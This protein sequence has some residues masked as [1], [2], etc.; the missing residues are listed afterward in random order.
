MSRKFIS[1]AS[2]FQSNSGSLYIKY[3]R[4]PVK[5]I[6]NKELVNLNSELSK[7]P[8]WLWRS[9]F[10]IATKPDNNQQSDGKSNRK[11]KIFT[12]AYG[13]QKNVISFKTYLINLGKN[14]LAVY[15][16][17]HDIFK[18]FALCIWANWIINWFCLAQRLIDN[19]FNFFSECE[20]LW[21]FV[22]RY[23]LKHKLYYF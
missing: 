4:I 1:Y 18:S 16:Q 3:K 20:C 21:A 17:Q 7:D 9:C 13:Q 11:F 15:L 12:S 10:C 8:R 19:S 14:Y 22:F 6:M 5:K 2:K 23:I